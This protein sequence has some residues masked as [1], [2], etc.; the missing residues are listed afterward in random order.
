MIKGSNVMRIKPAEGLGKHKITRTIAVYEID[1]DGIQV[2]VDSGG[3]DGVYNLATMCSM[4]TTL[5]TGMF[6]DVPFDLSKK[7]INEMAKKAIE[8]LE[9]SHA[10]KNND[11]NAVDMML[12]KL[13]EMIGKMRN[14]REKKDNE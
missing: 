14:R 11:P 7:L 12:D 13:E 2:C 1:G 4:T 3:K 9:I 10:I 6:E 8:T 5:V